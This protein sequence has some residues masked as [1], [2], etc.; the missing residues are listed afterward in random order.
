MAEPVLVGVSVF[1][2][3][4]RR[5]VVRTLLA[6][7]AAVFA[8]LQ[9]A[10]PVFDGL[11]LP[12]LAFRLLV[13]LAMAGFPV[14]F[15][16][17]WVYE[18]TAEGI[19][20]TPG[21]PA[22]ASARRVPMRRW[23]QVAGLF[24]M[25][26]VLAAA[27]AAGVGRWRFPTEATDGRVGLAIFP[28]R[29]IPPVDPSW[30]EG[31]A[32]LLGTVLDGTPG[33]RVVDPWTLWRP[34][35]AD[36]NGAAEPPSRETAARLAAENDAHRYLLG[37]AVST[38]DR[39]DLT[40][41]IYQIGRTDAIASFAVTGSADEM[42]QVVRDIALHVL[43]R[44]WGT[45]PPS[46]VPAEL[47]FGATDSPDALKAYL[48]ARS[49]LRR[50][51]VDSANIAIDRALALDSTFVLALVDA[52]TIK[53]WGFSTRGQPYS[54][55][56]ELLAAADAV[57]DSAGPRTRLRLEATR[58]SVRT[59]GVTA[60]RA[61]RDLLQF[62]PSDLDAHVSLGYVLR[63]YGWQFG[64]NLLEGRDA[65]EAVVRL[66]STN[67]PILVAR[68]WWAV[69]LGD[70]ADQR[71]QLERIE[72][73]DT[74]VALGRGWAAALKASLATDVVFERTVADLVTRPDIERTAMIRTLRT[75]RP[76]RAAALLGAM[77]S[78]PD[79]TAVAWSRLEL[80]RLEIARGRFEYVDSM[81]AASEF[82]PAGSLATL[83]FLLL[84]AALAGVSQDAAV[85]RAAADLSAYL[86]PDS[87]R[88]HFETRPVW[89]GGW[90]LGAWHGAAGDTAVTRRWIEAIGTLPGGGSPEEWAAALQAD[91][92]SRLAARRGDLSAALQHAKVSFERWTIHA[93]NA[94]EFMPAPQ[95]R[96]NLALLHRQAGQ[97][98]SARL[99]FQSLTPPTTWAGPLTARA[100][101]E[102][103]DIA[104]LDGDR[105]MAVLHFTRA[106]RMWEDGGDA[107]QPWL[108]GLRERLTT[109]IGG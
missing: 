60:Y 25:V 100:S 85:R 77:R 67:M 5:R 99:L 52:I 36:R 7:S 104:L 78:S 9:G 101:F 16:L 74:T 107:V 93:D 90:L 98:D 3:L 19:R 17:A 35:R 54:G 28:V 45:R 48:A 70:T 37:S 89:L 106:L 53:S 27:T 81:M 23:L 15:V 47:D 40:I 102:L 108:Q 59:D 10:Q 31:S 91:L 34:L 79:P 43:A 26:A 29:I 105:N 56:F 72:R 65:A 62:D 14:V 30:S 8:V 39:V 73:V 50:G 44:V 64:A 109:L 13:L 76:D 68:A 49:A 18:L 69:A 58:A 24:V 71:V 4:K 38:G 41:R 96:L 75:T 21:G 51:L 63:A 66:D 92:E 80:P 6:Y 84:A 61:G 55:F 95:I 83:D 2:E 97:L 20:R 87:A 57:A 94:P 86:A 22:R 1:E 88:A 12:D 103:G 82:Q 42:Q 46:D 32:D 11:L 33:L